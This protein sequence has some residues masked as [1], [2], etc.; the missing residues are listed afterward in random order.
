M[1]LDK[2]AIHAGRGIIATPAN[3]SIFFQFTFSKEREVGIRSAEV[4]GECKRRSKY[5]IRIARV[6]LACTLV[7]F[8]T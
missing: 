7:E 2:N 1:K 3:N 8:T 6:S 5:E 4:L